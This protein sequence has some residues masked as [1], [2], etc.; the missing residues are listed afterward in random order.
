MLLNVGFEG[1]F[2]QGSNIS[3]RGT[4][5]VEGVLRHHIG[6]CFAAL[7]RRAVDLLHDVAPRLKTFEAAKKKPMPGSQ[8]PPHPLV[9]ASSCLLY[10]L[11]KTTAGT[12]L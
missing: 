2:L 1:C 12:L 9:E 3:C 7:E 8:Q 10:S 11:V 6:A 5:V 4:E